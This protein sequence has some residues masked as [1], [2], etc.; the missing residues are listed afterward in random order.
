MLPCR[1]R[2]QLLRGRGKRQHKACGGN[3][4][5]SGRAQPGGGARGAGSV[6]RNDRKRVPFRFGERGRQHRL[7][8][9]LYFTHRFVSVRVR[10]G[11]G[12]R[13]AGLPY[14][15]AAGSALWA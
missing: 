12:G 8:R 9:A 4:R 2:P 6:H 3:H 7:L 10:G 15:A 5:H 14:R 11:S 13:G 1:L